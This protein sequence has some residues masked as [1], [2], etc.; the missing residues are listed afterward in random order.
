MEVLVRDGYF[1]ILQF[2][3]CRKT[4]EVLVRQGCGSA[5][6]LCGSGSK[7]SSFSECGSRSRSGSGSRSRS[8]STKFE[9][10]KSWI[11]FL[12]CKKQK[13]LLKSKKQWSLC[14]FTLKNLI[15]LQ[16]LAIS[17]HFSVF[18]GQIYPTGSGS[19]SRRENECGSMRIRIHSP[20]VRDGYFLILQFLLCRKTMEVLVKDDYFL[21][22]QFLLCRKTMEVLVRDGFTNSS[23]CYEAEVAHSI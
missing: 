3:L 18:S 5:F 4:M 23:I 13:R 14:K 21:I 8:S 17:L 19:G 15:M 12:S 7:S 20:V 9:E 11:V 10:K 16:L 6:T 2:L 22:L 1:L